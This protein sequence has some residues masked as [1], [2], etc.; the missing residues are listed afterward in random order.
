M[1]TIVRRPASYTPAVSTAFRE[2]DPF[3]VL[4]SMMRWNGNTEARPARRGEV[5]FA[6]RFDIKENKDSYLFSADLPGVKDEDLD[7]SLTGNQLTISGKRDSEHQEENENYF[8]LERRYGTFSRSFT[9]PDSANTES[10]K[11]ELKEGVLRVEL[12]KRVEAQPRKVTLNKQQG[13]SNK[14]TA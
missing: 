10:V 5:T 14:P 13:A 1:M 2:W 11:A 8:V 12:P 6:P 3:R 7:I 4:D 9:L